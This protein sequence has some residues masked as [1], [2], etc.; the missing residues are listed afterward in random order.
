MVRTHLLH[1]NLHL[2]LRRIHIVE[3]F[4]ATFAGIILAFRIK[5]I[6]MMIYMSYAA[7]GKPQLVETSIFR[8]IGRLRKITFQCRCPEKQ[9]RPEV[10]II[11]QRTGEIV[12]RGSLGHHTIDTFH[13][14]RIAH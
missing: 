6:A 1:L 5:I 2:T 13:I 3:L 11:T 10:E 7:H 4:F 12:Y 9:H 14:M 8:L